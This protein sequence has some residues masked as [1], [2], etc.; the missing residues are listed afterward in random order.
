M[1]LLD[2]ASWIFLCVCIAWCAFQLG[3]LR[4]ESEQD[5][6][7]KRLILGLRRARAEVHACRTL[8]EELRQKGGENP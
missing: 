5:V 7:V 1:S 8:I 6:L 4:A 2:V 3:R